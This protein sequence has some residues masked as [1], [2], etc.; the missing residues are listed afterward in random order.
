M[1]LKHEFYKLPLR[2]DVERLR[3]ELAAFPESDWQTHPSD[4]KGNLAI[5]LVSVNGG[6]NDD[7]A[8]PMQPTPQLKRSPYM[9]Q[10]IAAFK[11][12]CSRSR[13]MRL[14]GRHDVPLHSDINY[15]W[16]SRVRIHVPIVTTPDV[17]FHCG[18]QQVHMAEG[19]AWIFDSW[20]MHRV[21]NPSGKTRVHLVIDTSGSPEFWELVE[22]AEIFSSSSPPG[23]DVTPVQVPFQASAKVKIRT[24]RF[25]VPAVMSAGEV[26]AL[27]EGLVQ[28]V[29]SVAQNDREQLERYLAVLNTFR[30]AWRSIWSVHGAEKT[31]WLDYELLIN[32]TREKVLSIDAG[33]LL[34]NSSSAP[35]VM[36][37]RILVSALTPGLAEGRVVTAPG[38]PDGDTP[39]KT[40]RNSPCPCGS[41]KKYKRC[42]GAR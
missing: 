14:E 1:K 27:V 3:K 11:S 28:D 42:H 8:G 36:C 19:E 33:L 20:K 22:S 35:Q 13:L 7:F 15:H 38:K 41:G 16:W 31:G 39:E 37:A 29:C 9:Q 26:D 12:V 18:D 23:P 10:V 4:Y 6:I 21:V 32:K 34:S 40:G 5:P 2:F 24:E 25:N 30:F 17:I